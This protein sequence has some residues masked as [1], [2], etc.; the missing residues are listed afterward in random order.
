MKFK[1]VILVN[2]DDFKKAV[3]ILEA[4]EIEVCSTASRL[5]FYEE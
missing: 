4:A 5:A 3:A 1:D 2:C